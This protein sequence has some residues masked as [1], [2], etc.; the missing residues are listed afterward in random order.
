MKTNYL[1][2]V[3]F[4]FLVFQP[5]ASFAQID[6][7]P[8][9]GITNT[10]VLFSAAGDVTNA[11]TISTYSGNVG[12]NAGTLSGFTSL[13][14]QPTNLYAATPETAQCAADLNELYSDLVGRLGT[15]RAGAYTTETLTPG[16]Y[17][18]AGAASVG[19]ILTLD[20]SGDPNARFIIKTGGAF[21]M[22]A[23]AKILLTNGTQAKNVFWVIAGACAIAATCEARGMFICY[24][25]AISMGASCIMQGGALTITGAIT[26]LDG[27][28]LAT[29]V[30]L[31]TNTMV[32]SSNKTI[33]SGT[34]PADLVLTGNI[35]PVIKWQSSTDSNFSNF[36]DILHYTT[37]LSGSCIGPLTTTT[38]YRAVILI[39]GVL[40]YS[41][42]I[43]ITT[44][45]A[46]NTDSFALFTTAGAI[47]NTG[48]S[49]INAL[50]GTNAGAITGTF[51]NISLFRIQDAQT[52]NFANNL[53]PLFNS[54]KNTATTSNHAASLGAGEI[55]LPGVYEIASAATLG[56]T[57]T[58]DGQGSDEIFIIKITGAL[59][60]AANSKV[61][62]T[63]GAL[64]ANVF[65]VLDGALGVGASC[66][67]KGTFICLA[68]AIALGDNC[69]TDGGLFTIAGA[70]TLQNCNVSIPPAST[71]ILSASQ[72]I[73][74]GALPADLVLTGNISPIIKWQSA[75]NSAFT[76]PTDIL[77]SSTIL[78]G[79]C[80]GP[81]ITTTFYRVVMLID[82]VNAYSNSVK[83]TTTQ[84]PINGSAGA[85]ALFTTAGAITNA[86]GVSINNELIG[87]NAGAITGTFSNMSLLHTADALTLAFANDLLTLFNSKKD[88]PT[89]STHAA[90]Y[91]PDEIIA[92]GVYQISSAATMSGVLTLDGQNN[93]NSIFIIKI[94]G[95]LSLAAGTE[96]KLINGASSSNIF[97]IMDGALAVGASCKVSGTFICLAG[98]IALGNNCISEGRMFTI[99][100]A[101]TLQNCTLSI[102]IIPTSNQVILSGVQP[103]DLTLTGNIDGVVRWEKSSDSLFTTPVAIANITKTLTGLQIGMLT[104]TTYFRAVVTLF[105]NTINSNICTIAINQATIPVSAG[106]GSSNPSL[107]INTVLTTITHTTTG[108]TGIGTATGFPKGVTALWASNLITISGTPTVSGIFNYSIPLTG[109]CGNDATGTITVYPELVILV[110]GTVS[111]NQAFCSASVPADLILS[112]Y[113]G[114]VVKWQS[115]LTS[116][117]A[118]ATD[119][120]STETTLTGTSIGSLTGTTYFRAVVQSCTEPIRYAVPAKISIAILTTWN[121]TSWTNGTPNKSK[122]VVFAGNYTANENIDACSITINNGAIVIMNSGFTMTIT[123]ELTISGGGSLTFENTASLVQI[124]DG[125]INSGNITYK[126]Q[127]SLVRNSDYTYWSSPVAPQTLVIPFPNAPANRIYS[128]NAFA[129]LEAW[130][131]EVPS[132][133]MSIG[134]GYIVQGPQNKNPLALD[135]YQA[136]FFG[137]PN[138]GELQTP[139]GPAGTS[140]LIGNPYPCAIDAVSFL[141]LNASILEGT[142]YF[143]THSTAIQLASQIANPGSGAYAYTSDDYASYNSVGGVAVYP[144][145]IPTGKIAAGQAFFTTSIA[146]NANVLFNNAMRSA[147]GVLGVINSQFFKVSNTKSKQSTRIEKSRIWL[148][149]TNTQGTFKQTL[150]GYATGAT[151]DIDRSYDGESFDGNEFVDFYSINSDK[152]LV[153][154]GRALPFDINDQVPL[155]FKTTI[156]GAFSISIDHLDGLLINQVVLIEDKLTNT[157]TD[158]T[159][160]PYTFTTTEG[161]FNDRFVLRYANNNLDT[162]DFNSK[163]SSVLVYHKNKQISIISSS[164]KIEKVSVYDLSG[165]KVFQKNNVNNNAFSITDLIESQEALLVKTVL[166]NKKVVTTKL[167]Y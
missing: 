141:T 165:R 16:V 42:R 62:L 89:T 124:N 111:S 119:I 97:W 126:R 144:G 68:G 103:Q 61:I 30:P 59:A 37:R 35:S 159:S 88:T 162:A 132:A 137:T 130:K 91:S 157:L 49:S 40:A 154:Q 117:F 138:N 10:F 18:T 96:I 113:S 29:A 25:G 127:S 73:A 94:T 105:S 160:G 128:F 120:Y 38:Y 54:L 27:M 3:A 24:A 19:G 101:I 13:V 17:T 84:P 12:T 21:T 153:I 39:D 7:A 151:N 123:N 115:S 98:G 100:G 70:I 131:Q 116:D 85:F 11:G 163:K 32:L 104:T 155:G 122:I 125:A 65:W 69:T 161:T 64:A 166:Q 150:V 31:V 86:A 67:V 23:G 74:I 6:P 129:S 28:T 41:N 60:M 147:G 107:Y 71:V 34:I 133:N 167:M 76:N 14:T 143:W 43:K 140:N 95:A 108:A 99:A 149:L 5:K 15:V 92:P 33:L 48:T 75:S 8:D 145:G 46:P 50:I 1:F 135:A 20:G 83:I 93:P 134:K 66:A 56:G 78:T 45:I 63:N 156:D 81:L 102:P 51:S 77:R 90:T 158:L 121:G 110:G 72:T 80:V 2:L 164:E 139:I 57:L 9:V 26:T 148:N 118:I 82:G 52:L 4:I 22:G 146:T 106:A 136:H 79:S 142:I 44:I 55:L 114:G 152:N 112:G 109:G 53:L 47:T 58:L 87:T 36:S